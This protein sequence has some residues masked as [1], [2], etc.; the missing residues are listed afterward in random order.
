MKKQILF[1]SFLGLFALSYLSAQENNTDIE[2]PAHPASTIVG[3]PGIEIN[4]V[5]NYSSLISSLTSSIIQNNN[6]LPTDLAFEIAPHYTKSQSDRRQDQLS[7]SDFLRDLRISLAT[8]SV[9]PMNSTQSF[10]RIGIGFRS[11]LAV[12]QYPEDAKI[13]GVKLSEFGSIRTIARA[14]SQEMLPLSQT[15]LESLIEENPSYFQDSNHRNDWPAAIM[16]KLNESDVD[17]NDLEKIRAV[18]RSWSEE[19]LSMAN[20]NEE[21]ELVVQKVYDISKRYGNIWEI[22]GAM[23]LD[24]PTNSASYSRVN[25]AGVWMSYHYIDKDNPNTEFSAIGRASNYSY[26][27]A[28]LS[29]DNYYFDLGVNVSLPIIVDA[30]DLTAEY[31]YRENLNTSNSEGKLSFTIDYELTDLA[32]VQVTYSQFNGTWEGSGLENPS[33]LLLGLVYAL[34]NR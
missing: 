12:G 18:L 27:P 8:K 4:R 16:Q 6:S 32:M 23:A 14:I 21:I 17:L 24:F 7:E 15:D 1:T 5:G 19:M 31:V 28:D 22:S 3:S 9:T 11:Y 29:T 30:V 13:I 33:Q 20:Q 2:I 34:S 10:N 26:D 25:R